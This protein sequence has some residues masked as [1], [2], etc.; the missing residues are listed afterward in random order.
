[1]SADAAPIPLERFAEAIV[2][3]PLANLHAKAAELRNSIAHL[4]TSNEQLQ[5]YADDGDR[6]CADAIREN[7][8]VIARM[9]ARI[10]LLRN[11]VENRGFRWGEEQPA[12]ANGEIGDQMNHDRLDATAPPTSEAHLPAQP[13]RTQGG[14]LEDGE[15]ARRLREQ[16]DEEMPDDDEG[17]HL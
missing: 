16:M 7:E 5:E 14:S 3:L 2:E 13:A 9:E 12:T 8:D 17:V 11:E 10:T 6:D 4:V 15:L 1:M